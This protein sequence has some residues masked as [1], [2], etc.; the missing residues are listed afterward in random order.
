[1]QIYAGILAVSRS[2]EVREFARHHLQTELEHRQFFD[3]WLPNRHKSR[4][5]LLWKLSSWLLGAI[6]AF[7][8]ARAVFATIAAVESFVES[9][10]QSQIEAMRGTPELAELAH[11]LQSFCDDEVEHQKDA[12]ARLHA[13]AGPVGRAWTYTVAVGSAVGV[14]MAKRF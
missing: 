9:H 10:Y 7:F 1:M 8:G 11:T 5:I 3:E 12:A 13:P 14:S 6:P 4:L 2:S